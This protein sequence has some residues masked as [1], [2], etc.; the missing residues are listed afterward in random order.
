LKKS[1]FE[2]LKMIPFSNCQIF[3]FSNHSGG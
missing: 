1:G 2:N 3:K